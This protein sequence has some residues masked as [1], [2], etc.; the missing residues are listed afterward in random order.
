MTCLFVKIVLVS[1]LYSPPRQPNGK[2]NR[3]D[4]LDRS[5]PKGLMGQSLKV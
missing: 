3:L 5:R 4:E 1:L 2:L